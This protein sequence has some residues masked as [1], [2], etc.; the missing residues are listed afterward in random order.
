MT[1][2]EKIQKAEDVLRDISKTVKLSEEQCDAVDLAIITLHMSKTVFL[3]NESL[4]K[5]TDVRNE[6]HQALM[7]LKDRIPNKTLVDLFYLGE[8]YEGI[9]KELN[10]MKD[11]NLKKWVDVWNETV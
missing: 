3:I 11:C 6:W 9:I 2:Q 10:Q 4:T 8:G 5:N 7:L 1:Y